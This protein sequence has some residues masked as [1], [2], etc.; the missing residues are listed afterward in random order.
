MIRI[1]V[2]TQEQMDTGCLQLGDVEKDIMSL[3]PSLVGN[4]QSQSNHEEMPSK[5][6]MSGILFKR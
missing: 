2:P 3:A 4:A 1:T 5:P 6:K